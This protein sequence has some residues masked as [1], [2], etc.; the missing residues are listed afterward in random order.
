MINKVRRLLGLQGAQGANKQTAAS[1][2][3]NATNRPAVSILDIT[4]ET[5]DA[6]LRENEGLILV[7]FWADWCQPCRVMSAY[8]TMLAQNFA[9]QLHVAAVDVDENPAVSERFIVQGLPT[10]LFLRSDGAGNS[11]EVDRVVGIIPYEELVER[12]ESNITNSSGHS[13]K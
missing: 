11:V 9:E 13:K 8:V 1:T 5:I 2:L 10:L 3:E 4:D 6:V 7:D 12:T